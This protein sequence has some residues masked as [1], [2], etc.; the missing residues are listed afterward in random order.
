MDKYWSIAQFDIYFFK[1]NRVALGHFVFSLLRIQTAGT[2]VTII[3]DKHG[4][5]P[6]NTSLNIMKQDQE[7]KGLKSKS[8]LV[9]EI[10]ISDH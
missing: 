6:S 3:Y 10:N 7:R 8:L 5:T 9:P 1:T 2:L 4:Q